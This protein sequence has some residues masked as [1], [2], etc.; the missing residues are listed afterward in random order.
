MPLERIGLSNAILSKIRRDTKRRLRSE[1]EARTHHII[2]APEL[3]KTSGILF[4]TE[5]VR[6]EHI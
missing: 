3:I 2:P 6:H 5:N 4:S 1:G